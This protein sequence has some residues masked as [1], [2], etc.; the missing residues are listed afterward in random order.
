[1]KGILS[2]HR[3][4]LANGH[5]ILIEDESREDALQRALKSGL[6]SPIKLEIAVKGDLNTVMCR[7]NDFRLMGN[8]RS[9]KTIANLINFYWY[10]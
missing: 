2:M 1:M 10:S 5:T 8:K 9:F 3:F 6:D 4:E 7:P